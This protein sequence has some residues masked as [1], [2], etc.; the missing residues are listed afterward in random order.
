[1]ARML[2]PDDF[3]FAARVSLAVGSV[4]AALHATLP[5][6]AITDDLDGV[7]EP[8]TD[9]G[10]QHHAWIRERGLPGALDHHEHP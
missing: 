4:C 10:K 3:V 8:V 5:A 1:M 2:L 9:V 6:K 7:A